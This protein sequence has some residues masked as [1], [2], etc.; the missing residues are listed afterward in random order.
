MA[1]HLRLGRSRE[2]ELRLG[3][4]LGEKASGHSR[5]LRGCVRLLALSARSLALSA[6]SLALFA[7]LLALFARMELLLALFSLAR[8]TV[9]L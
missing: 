1:H 2:T 8:L 5:C 9:A 4:L 3:G 6:R 7:R